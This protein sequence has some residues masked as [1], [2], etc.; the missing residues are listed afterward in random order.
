M[1]TTLKNGI[2]SDSSLSI[3]QELLDYILDFLH[4]DVPTLR[5]C[6][7]VSHAFLP[8]SRYHIYSSAFIGHKYELDP[9]RD[10]YAGQLYQSKNLAALLKHSPHVAPLVTRFG[11]HAM[12][13]RM[14]EF[15]K[16]T[17]L[18]PIIQS[19]RN[20]SH[21]EFICRQYRRAPFPVAT[22]RVF[23]AALCSVLL[24]TFICNGISFEQGQ[25]EDLLTAATNPALKHMSLVCDHGA[26]R[27]SEPYPPIRPPPD[28]LPALESLCIA[29]K[30]ISS[31]I[32]WL[33]F[34]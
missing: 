32:A 33:F 25:F 31:N 22:L 21:I 1:T 10:Q 13:N 18:F 29:G 8:C 9:F 17:S 20:L 26:D 27:A 12:S 11:I 4:D 23:L 19:L 30:A 34:H 16:D 14:T 3:P 6:S 28:G 2:P 24:K 5:T 15:L 7:L